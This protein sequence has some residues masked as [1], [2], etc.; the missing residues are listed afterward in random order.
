MLLYIGAAIVGF[1]LGQYF[2]DR[3]NWDLLSFG[4]LHVDLAVI[5]AMILLL[6]A[7]WLARSTPVKKP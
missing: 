3:M 6:V 1:W 4:A 7:F 5:G 2:A